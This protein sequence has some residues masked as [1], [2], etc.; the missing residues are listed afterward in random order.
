MKNKKLICWLLVIVFC[1]TLASCGDKAPVSSNDPSDAVSEVA[2]DI[3]SDT[4]SETSSVPDATATSS[5]TEEGD[6]EP[7]WDGPTPLLYRVTDDENHVAWVFGSV[8]VGR[9]EFYPFPDYLYYSYHNAE[10]LAVEADIVA[11]QED[12]EAQIKA[13]TNFVYLDGT[14]IRSH[15]SGDLY[16]KAVEILTENGLYTSDLDYYCPYF[17]ANTIDS[18][19]RAKIGTD[20]TLGIDLNLILDA[21]QNKKTIDEIESVDSQYK[22]LSGFSDQIQEMLLISAIEAYENPE[23]LKE[24]TNKLLDLWATGDEEAFAKYLE[25]QDDEMAGA[26]KKLYEEYNKAM[27][28]DR[29]VSMTQYV[30][31]ALESG[32]KTFVCVGVAHVVGEGGIIDLLEQKG[33][34]IIPVTITKYPVAYSYLWE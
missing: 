26:E 31:K 21:K 14:T 10:V 32:K 12:L 27:I 17:W 24:E 29:N 16:V 33:Y 3:V 11:F 6:A 8:H 5:Q 22:M 13:L 15:L 28:T 19:T 9:E 20:E 2:S 7:W 4:A 34:N 1:F 23:L 30:E 25:S 18:L